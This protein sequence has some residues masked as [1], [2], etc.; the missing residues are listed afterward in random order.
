ME[1]C[2]SKHVPNLCAS[3]SPPCRRPQLCIPCLC[4]TGIANYLASLVQTVLFAHATC[5]EASS[6]SY[7]EVCN[8]RRQAEKMAAQD[9]L[10]KRKDPSWISWQEV[11]QTRVAIT[12]A[13]NAANAATKRSMLRDVVIVLLH[14]ITPPDRVG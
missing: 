8:L 9:Q 10:F 2:A 14:S 6:G 3:H 1:Q 5:E 7:D 4:A 13:Y 11:Q 12:N